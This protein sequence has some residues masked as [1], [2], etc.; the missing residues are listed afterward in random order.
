MAEALEES[1]LVVVV[2]E[3]ALVEVLEVD[4]ADSAVE[5]LVVVVQVEI[6]N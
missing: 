5:A 2:L 4:S 6:G 3:E 1:I